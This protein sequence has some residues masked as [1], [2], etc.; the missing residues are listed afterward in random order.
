[1]FV[2]LLVA[3]PIALFLIWAVV[4]DLRKRRRNEPV[5]D[6][7]AR[8]VASRTRIQAEGKSSEWGAGL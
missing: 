2:A 6:H 8:G 3:V 1:M 5:T 7:D 4:F